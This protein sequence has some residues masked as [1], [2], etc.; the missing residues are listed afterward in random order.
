[1][2]GWPRDSVATIRSRPFTSGDMW[3]FGVK[4]RIRYIAGCVAT[5]G[6]AN[7][8]IRWYQVYARATLMFVRMM[9]LTGIPSTLTSAVYL[10]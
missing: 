9:S 5:F 4:R 6:Q 1:M 10:L 8:D 3:R 7:A 2:S